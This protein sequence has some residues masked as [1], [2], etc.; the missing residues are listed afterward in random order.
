[1][2]S[3]LWAS[4]HKPS[5]AQMFELLGK[6][7]NYNMYLEVLHPQLMNAISNIQ[8]DDNLTYLANK[9]IDLCIKHGIN[10]LVQPSGS[11]AFM[12]T[13]GIAISAHNMSKDIND[14]PIDILFA[15]SNRVSKEVT[16]PDG[17]VKK[18]STFNHVRFVFV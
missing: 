16:Q 10:Y 11:P 13:L 14:V 4:V 7:D 3:I 18:V 9:L 6:T 17:S 8:V 1:M 5:E 12:V 15:H 2:K